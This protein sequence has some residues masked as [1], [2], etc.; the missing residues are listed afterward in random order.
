[1]TISGIPATASGSGSPV[2]KLWL[3]AFVEACPSVRVI[4]MEGSELMARML[5]GSNGGAAH[6]SGNRIDQPGNATIQQ[7]TATWSQNPSD[8]VVQIN[9]VQNEPTQVTQNILEGS[10]MLAPPGTVAST[11]NSNG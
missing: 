7:A 1:M 5:I 8:P 3:T 4:L 6:S 10:A 9:V 11:P 2:D